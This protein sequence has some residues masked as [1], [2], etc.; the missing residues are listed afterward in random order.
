MAYS[1]RFADERVHGFQPGE[2]SEQIAEAW[3]GMRRTSDPRWVLIDEGF[4][5]AREHE[6]ESLFAT[7]NGHV[8]TRASLE[9]GSE[10]SAPATFV[11]GIFEHRK[12]PGAVPA[13]VRFPD[14]AG[15]TI[16]A[17]GHRLS[18][19]EGKTLDHRRIL[20]LKKGALW[21]EWRHRDTDGRITCFRSLRLASL[22]DRRLL[23]QWVMFTAENY[24]PAFYLE[25]SLKLPRDMQP[26]LPRDWHPARSPEQVNVLP[27]VLSVPGRDSEAVFCIGSQVLAQQ[28]KD[29][30]RHVEIEDGHIVEKFQIHAGAGAQ[31]HLLRMVSVH[32]ARKSEN[33]RDVVLRHFETLTANDLSTVAPDTAASHASAWRER[34]QTADVE[35]QGDDR[36]QQALRF[37]IYHLISAADPENGKVSIGARALTGESYKGHVFW[38]TEIYMLPFYLYTHPESARSLLE[39]RYHTLPAAREK[40][41]RSG[42]RGAMY[43][44]ESA[45]TGEDVTP[46]AI[47]MPTGEVLEVRIAEM[48][49]HITADIAYAV[50][51]YWK[52]TGDDEFFLERGAE[53]MLEST[54]FWASR[55]NLEADRIYHIRHVIGPDEYH[56]DVDDDAYTNLMAAWNLRRGAE[57]ALVLKERWVDRWHEITERL[58]L[59]EEEVALWPKLADAI[60]TGFDS[61]T[62]LFEQF[63]GYFKKEQIDLKAYEP[64]SAAMD[65]ILGYKRLQATNIVKQPDVL[66]AIY[67]LWDDFSP[68]VRAANFRYYEPRTAHG[69]SLSPSIHALLAARLGQMEAAQRYLKQSAEIDLEN[70]TSSAAGGVH[71]AAIG[72][73]WQAAVFGFAGLQVCSD[74]LRLAPNLLSHWRRLSFPM[75]WRKRR[76]QISL[77]PGKVRVGVQGGKPLKLYLA[78]GP[79]VTTVP[80][81]EYISE[82]ENQRWS[83]WRTVG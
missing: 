48:E 56:D 13:L 22:A 14:W 30:R 1:N 69:S 24:C 70:S 58:L 81:Q 6:I 83:A 72:G 74:E 25:S 40:A 43:A 7:S 66:M 3:A 55:G 54:R 29:S 4:T 28:V 73:L 8:G 47:I 36:I 65:V 19:H 31:C 10:L 82:R 41:Q 49:V 64:R 62:L 21:R 59:T 15:I 26:L 75:T 45:D 67:L 32:T 77:Q 37:A 18:M 39:Y 80:G 57:T 23:L 42:Y 16:W 53:I 50:W 63:S 68:E 34:W 20:D 52:M 27:L 38:D 11:A 44:W 33:P 46:A 35:I 71:A 5:L 61:R 12:A 17:N 76:L 60:P 51:Q 79:E 78:D 2:L 9:E